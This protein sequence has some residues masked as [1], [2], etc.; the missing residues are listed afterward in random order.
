[1]GKPLIVVGSITFAMKGRDV[2]G[3]RGIRASVER[4][5][6]SQD[7]RGC[8][9]GLYVPARTDEAERILRSAGVPVTGRVQWGGS[10]R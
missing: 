7:A 2:L 5:P 10:D 6:H 8:G 9:Y 1:M 4:V 3:R